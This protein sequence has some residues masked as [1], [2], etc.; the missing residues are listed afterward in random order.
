[1]A[2]LS[3]TNK[4]GPA[5]GN[6]RAGTAEQDKKQRLNK[7]LRENLFKR[8]QQKRFRQHEQMT[9]KGTSAEKIN[10]MLD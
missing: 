8:K 6:K 2:N 5:E 3:G 9:K 10:G 7:A 1:M 4:V